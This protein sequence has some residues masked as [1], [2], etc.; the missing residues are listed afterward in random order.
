MHIPNPDDT[1]AVVAGGIAVSRN[2]AGNNDYVSSLVSF[3]HKK[4]YAL[5]W[6]PEIVLETTVTSPRPRIP[7]RLFEET[8][9]ESTVRLPLTSIA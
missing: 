3:G 2:R 5:S 4:T 8:T 7:P 9:V 1:A 6:F